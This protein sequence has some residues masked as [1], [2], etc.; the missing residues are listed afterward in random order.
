MKHSHYLKSTMAAKQIRGGRGRREQGVER[1]Q[2]ASKENERNLPESQH[3]W[4]NI[5]FHIHRQ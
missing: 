1:E 5:H 4:M 2:G 3:Q